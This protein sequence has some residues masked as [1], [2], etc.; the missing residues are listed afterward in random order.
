MDW[1][2]IDITDVGDADVGT[3]VTIIGS[4][5]DAAIKA[6]DI[7]A[8]LSTISYEVTCGISARVPR[9]FEEKI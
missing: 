2:T 5:R 9:L 3:P 6:E 8:I 1:V 4:D 7:A